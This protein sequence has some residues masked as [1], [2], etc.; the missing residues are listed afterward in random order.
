MPVRLQV[1]KRA[2]ERLRESAPEVLAGLGHALADHASRVMAASAVEVPRDTGA[3]A[4]SAFVDGPVTNL[5]KQSV[6]ATG[7][8]ADPHAGAIHEGF[9][10]GRKVKSPPHFLSRPF[11]AVKSRARKAVAEA[12]KSAISRIGKG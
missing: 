3:L 5:A 8:Y 11:K 7:G 12:L 10:H 9:H 4:G 2:L 6:T 1:D